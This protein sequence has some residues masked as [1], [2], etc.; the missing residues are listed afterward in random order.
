M[1]MQPDNAVPT[2]SDASADRDTSTDKNK[3]IDASIPLNSEAI[4][5]AWQGLD[6][7]ASAQMRRVTEP[8]E[9]KDQPAFYRLVQPLGWQSDDARVKRALLRIIFCLTAGKT[10]LK[11]TDKETSLGAGLA[12]S[13]KINEQRIFQLIRS[14]APSDM[15]HLRRLIIHA[16]PSVNWSKFVTTLYYWNKRAKQNLLEDF[17]IASAPTSDKKSA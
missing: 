4:W 1:T 6:N 17:V 14:D 15:V 11:R 3:T 10:S 2:A 8:E 7:A 5:Q 12:A 16:E 13:K 9:L